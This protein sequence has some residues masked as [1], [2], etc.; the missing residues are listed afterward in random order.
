MNGIRAGQQC[1]L[2]RV[3]ATLEVT[4]V[5]TINENTSFNTAKSRKEVTVGEKPPARSVPFA[6]DTNRPKST[7]PLF[8]S[9]VL[10]FVSCHSFS[11]R[12]FLWQHQ[13]RVQSQVRTRSPSTSVFCTDPGGCVSVSITLFLPLCGV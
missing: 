9:S 11:S 5:L 10:Q 8:I 1:N 3:S 4:V 6:H 12:P 13:C 2:M 7:S